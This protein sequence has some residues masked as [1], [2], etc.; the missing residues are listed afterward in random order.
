MISS[1]IPLSS[2]PRSPMDTLLYIRGRV[3]VD[4]AAGSMEG[5]DL[6][7]ETPSNDCNLSTSTPD[8]PESG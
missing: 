5:Y 8:V 2:G 7:V 4:V 3:S 1:L 6:P